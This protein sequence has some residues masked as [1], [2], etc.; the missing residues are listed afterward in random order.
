MRNRDNLY[1]LSEIVE[2]D[3]EYYEIA[4]AEHIK[5]K[6][7]K[8]VQKQKNMAVMEESVTLEDI[9]KEK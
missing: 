7:S 1:T 9:E 2:F 8:R 4:T 3:E 5:L 6:R